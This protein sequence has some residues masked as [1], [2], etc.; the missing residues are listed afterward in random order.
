MVKKMHLRLIRVFCYLGE[1]ILVQVWE[2]L[3]IE[4]SKS[5]EISLFTRYKKHF[6]HLPNDS[7]DMELER[8]KIS[9]SDVEVDDNLK[10]CIQEAVKVL[11]QKTDYSRDDYKEFAELNLA[12]LNSKD[13]IKFRKPGAMHKVRF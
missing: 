5:P 7:S 4:A 12:Y 3:K 6:Q 11:S 2:D 8:I 10:K 13:E 1:L 9:S